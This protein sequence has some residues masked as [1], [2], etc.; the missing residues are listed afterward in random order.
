MQLVGRVGEAWG[1]VQVHRAVIMPLCPLI[2]IMEKDVTKEDPIIILPQFPF[3][4]LQA[5]TSLI[6]AGS[7][8]ITAVVTLQNILELMSSLGLNMPMDRLLVAREESPD[9]EIISFKQHDGLEIFKVSNKTSDEHVGVPLAQSTPEVIRN[10]Q[11][12]KVKR[13]R[14]SKIVQTSISNQ[15]KFLSTTKQQTRALENP[16]EFDKIIKDK[17]ISGVEAV[18]PKP[19]SDESVP[20]EIKV[21]CEENGN[22]HDFGDFHSPRKRKWSRRSETL[23]I[24]THKCDFCDFKCRF[25]KDLQEHCDLFHSNQ[26]FSCTKCDFKTSGLALLK[27]HVKKRHIGV[28]N[29]IC[30]ICGFR[31]DSKRKMT[32]HEVNFHVISNSRINKNN[33]VNDSQGSLKLTDVAYQTLEDLSVELTEADAGDLLNRDISED[34]EEAGDLGEAKLE[35]APTEN[36]ENNDLTDIDTT[37]KLQSTGVKGISESFGFDTRESYEAVSDIVNTKLSEMGNLSNLEESFSKDPNP[38]TDSALFT[39]DTNKVDESD[40]LENIENLLKQVPASDQRN[41]DNLNDLI[42][43]SEN[44]ATSNMIDGLKSEELSNTSNEVVGFKC[45]APNCSKVYRVSKYSTATYALNRLKGHYAKVHT[46]G[47]DSKFSY[48]IEYKK[49]SRVRQQDQPEVD[50]PLRI[51]RSV[52]ESH[53]KAAAVSKVAPRRQKEGVE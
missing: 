24:P 33:S 9:I 32:Y 37:N 43:D 4:L 8:P 49:D 3:E 17:K 47:E 20:V 53:K 15:E 25:L 2:R 10:A 29:I 48:S 36:L 41:Q 14:L 35:S 22:M 11:V 42:D 34:L 38:I 52:K 44:D 26:D 45:I 46:D 6:Y 23:Q 40:L 16:R 12:S 50:N 5:L 21:E 51:L 7:T 19:I 18:Q 28:G 39:N 1:S 13:R 30:Q 27:V 31:V